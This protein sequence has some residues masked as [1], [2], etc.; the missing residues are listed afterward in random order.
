MTN[1]EFFEKTVPMMLSDDWKERLRG[2]YFQLLKRHEKVFNTLCAWRRN[3]LDFEPSYD[4]FLLVEQCKAME[5]YL[6]ILYERAVEE[7]I[8]VTMSEG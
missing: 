5:E 8:D 3:E 2:E 6:H 1:K 4:Y 7:G